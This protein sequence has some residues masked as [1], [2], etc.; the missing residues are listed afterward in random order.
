MTGLMEESRGLA[1]AEIV[2][3]V[4]SNGQLPELLQPNGPGME[5]S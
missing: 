1:E 5:Y 4:Y 2:K 3:N